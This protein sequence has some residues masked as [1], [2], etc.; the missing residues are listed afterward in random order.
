MDRLKLSPAALAAVMT[1][2]LGCDGITGSLTPIDNPPTSDIVPGDGG[3]GSNPGE[4]SVPDGPVAVGEVTLEVAQRTIDGGANLGSR[5]SARVVNESD[6]TIE[7][8]LRFLRDAQMV[9]LA[10]LQV[11]PATVTTILSPDSADEVRVSGIDDA[12]EAI[13]RAT[14]VAG[15]DFDDGAPAVF[16]MFPIEPPATPEPEDPPEEPEVEPP[17]YVAPSIAALLPSEDVTLPIGST[18]LVGWTDESSVE[19]A[20]VLVGVRPA[21]ATEESAFVQAAPGVGEALDGINDQIRVVLQGIEPGNY[22]VVVAI[23]DGVRR[24]ESVAP[25]S[26]TLTRA[27]DNQAPTIELTRPNEPRELR[28][29]DALPVGWEDADA[30]DNATVTISLEP[31]AGAEPGTPSYV[32]SPP[33]AEDPDGAGA[34]DALLIITDALPGRYDLVGLIDDGEL[35]GTS[36]RSGWVTILPD[37]ENDVPTMR[38]V[39][40]VG[41]VLVEAGASLTISW[42]D[43]DEN[44][45]AMISLMLDP[46]TIGG[47]LDGDEFVLATALAEDPDGSGDSIRLGIPEGLPSGTYRVAGRITDGVSRMVAF[48]DAK[49]HVEA[50]G[51]DPPPVRFVRILG[52]DE[53]D[54]Y[55]RLGE[56]LKVEANIK[57]LADAR[58]FLSNMAYGGDVRVELFPRPSGENGDPGTL[59]FK[60][61]TTKLGIRN[62][63]WPR[64]FALEMVASVG[65]GDERASA[66]RPVWIFQDVTVLD[67]EFPGLECAGEVGVDDAPPE[68]PNGIVMS[69]YGGDA[70]QPFEGIDEERIEDVFCPYGYRS[71]VYDFWLTADGIIPGEGECTDED[72]CPRHRLFLTAPSSPNEIQTARV[73]MHALSWME[74]GQYQVIAVDQ[75][76]DI[77]PILDSSAG[78]LVVEL[79]FPREE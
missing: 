47:D 56:P 38:F 34:D 46:D 55:I 9:H 16:R 64:K 42:T 50:G 65:L 39:E 74:D 36:R 7:V 41:D 54:V 15:V 62:D 45:N 30:D 60:L 25:G 19:G 1:A 70:C 17:P 13:P 63:A 3:E 66:P 14:F 28:R 51:V 76:G 78:P 40:P 67:I 21:G 53:E 37:P 68:N 22:E 10:Y 4:P 31:S 12:G 43:S 24:V 69:W 26:L 35:V 58:F 2:M 49:L 52:G 23:D 11:L 59:T 77:T 61:P 18:L 79:C 27:P 32:I 44:D 48:A 20:V 73:P 72:P 8:T 57:E 33:L 71:H 29:G 5:V 6:R 75:F